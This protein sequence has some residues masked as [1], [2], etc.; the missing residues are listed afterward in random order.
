M[1]GILYEF[2]SF[3]TNAKTINEPNFYE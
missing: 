2:N 1:D 3:A